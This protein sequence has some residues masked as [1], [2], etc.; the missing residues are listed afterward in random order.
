MDDVLSEIPNSSTDSVI[1]PNCGTAMA[2]GSPYC[3]ACGWPMRTITSRE[4]NAGT[5]AYL[6]PIP[7]AI[8]LF[9][10]SYRRDR[11]VR[12]HAWQ[13]I[14]LWGL[15]L[16]LTMAALVLSNIAAALFFLVFGIIAVLAMIFLWVVLSI[17]AWQGE[18]FALP[19][20]GMLAGR[21]P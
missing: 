19:L 18:R 1:C 8:L 15:F 5:L 14:L 10:P 6:T 3:P 2:R 9:L 13:S 17:K 11:F 21:L 7:A 4:R 16:V 12:F 20:V